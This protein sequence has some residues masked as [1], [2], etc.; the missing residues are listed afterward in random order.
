MKVSRFLL[1]FTAIFLFF[2]IN[3]VSASTIWAN[4]VT[5]NSGWFDAEKDYIDDTLLCWAAS[6]ANIL[7]WSGWDSDYDNEDDILDFFDANTA[8]TRGWMDYAW[9]FWFDGTQTYWN[10]NHTYFDG[11]LHEGYYSTQNYANRYYEDMAGGVGVTW[12]IADLLQADYGV[13]VAIK[14]T[15]SHAITVWGVEVNSLGYTSGIWVTDSDDDDDGLM[16]YNL[17]LGDDQNWY[18]EDFYGQNGGYIDEIQ[19]LQKWPENTTTGPTVT[20][21]DRVYL[22]PSLRYEVPEIVQFTLPIPTYLQPE[23]VPEPATMLLF[24]FGLLGLAGVHRKRLS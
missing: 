14:G 16:Y 19:A 17:L 12:D 4:G 2:S 11:S 8:D 21:L 10:S 24:G 13:S 7:S 9:N 6:A 1:L 18:L 22:D 3:N 23:I 5:E 20:P 15:M